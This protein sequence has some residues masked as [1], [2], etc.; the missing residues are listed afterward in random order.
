MK[1]RLRCVLLGCVQA[2]DYPGCHFCQTAIYDDFIEVGKLDWFFR[3]RW[4]VGQWLRRFERH[5]CEHCRRK[6]WRGYNDHICSEE[7]F[8]EWLPF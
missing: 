6:F 7:C 3:L 2:E 1:H 4:R 5:T 8:D